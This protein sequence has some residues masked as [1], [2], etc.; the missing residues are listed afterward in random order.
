MFPANITHDNQ[1]VDEMNTY[2][3]LPLTF[4]VQPDIKLNKLLADLSDEANWAV[5]KAATQKLGAN[6]SPE[7][8]QGLLDALPN[9]PFWMVRCAI[10]Q[11][12]EM[13][14]DRMAIPTLQEVAKND[15]FQVVQ[16]YA[17]KAI[18]RLS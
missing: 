1:V 18:E 2:T 5:R 8:L 4:V 13:I 7:A 11:A 14:G 9:D 17:A 15:G 10:I 12:L 16:S 3:T 6:G